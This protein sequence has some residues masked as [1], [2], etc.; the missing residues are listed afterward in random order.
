MEGGILHFLI[1]GGF[2][3]LF[4]ALGW[5]LKNKDELQEKKLDTLQIALNHL[6]IICADLPKSYVM[7]SDYKDDM[8]EVKEMLHRIETKLDSKADRQ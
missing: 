1:T 4:G 7:K 2:T 6:T 8:R 5:A 3:L